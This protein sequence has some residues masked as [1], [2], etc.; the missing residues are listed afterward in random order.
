MFLENVKA[1]I[2]IPFYYF[3]RSVFDVTKG[4]SHYGSGGGYNHFAGRCVLWTLF[5]S[6]HFCC[7]CAWDRV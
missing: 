3:Y 5:S 1:D 4:K 7:C 2:L 6:K